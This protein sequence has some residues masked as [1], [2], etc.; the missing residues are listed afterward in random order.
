MC[1]LTSLR[2]ETIP[3]GKFGKIGIL[4]EIEFV[5][6]LSPHKAP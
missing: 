6:D 2:I 1:F 3:R 5:K 4:N